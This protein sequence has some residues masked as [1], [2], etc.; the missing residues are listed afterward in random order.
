MIENTAFKMTS[1][2]L[3]STSASLLPG[4]LIL[5]SGVIVWRL[6][7]RQTQLQTTTSEIN[8][9]LKRLQLQIA[10]IKATNKAGSGTETL[11]DSLKKMA[12]FNLWPKGK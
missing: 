1:S 8:N 4:T 9:E 3:A 6:W 12:R 11:T 5:L 7:H 10:E 2:K